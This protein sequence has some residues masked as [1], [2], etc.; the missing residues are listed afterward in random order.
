M[1]LTK[2]FDQFEITN[3]QFRKMAKSQLEVAKKLG[4]TGALSVEAETKTITKK[5]EGKTAKE[6]IIVDKLNCT[7]TGHMPVG[8]LR[9]VFGLTND[10]LKEGIYGYKT[11][12]T[13][14]SGNVTWDVYDI[15]RE[16]RKVIAFPN[17]TFTSGLKINITNG[18]EEIAEV[19]I[20][21]T[22]MA[23]E[24]NCLY[25]EGFADDISDEPTLKAWNTNFTSE[26]VKKAVI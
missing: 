10:E 19:E 24:N 22:A 5:C 2:Q 12:S 7:F 11:T 23:D 17:I 6:V 26:L 13:G 9:D 21:F 25:Y 4:C 3:G 20:P 18:E 14:A 16:S 15:G 8:V 1:D